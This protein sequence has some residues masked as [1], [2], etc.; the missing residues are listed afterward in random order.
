MFKYSSIQKLRILD[1]LGSFLLQLLFF[2][3]YLFLK[4]RFGNKFNNSLNLLAVYNNVLE[5]ACI[6]SFGS[7]NVERGFYAK[8]VH[9]N[10]IIRF[11]VSHGR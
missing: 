5:S 10:A 6:K 7:E 2:L 8:I 3:T 11:N 1:G 4:I 9:R